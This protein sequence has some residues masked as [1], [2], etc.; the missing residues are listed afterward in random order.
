MDRKDAYAKCVQASSKLTEFKSAGDCAWEDLR[1]GIDS[2]AEAVGDALKSAK[3]R[4]NCYHGFKA[5]YMGAF[6]VPGRRRTGCKVP[7]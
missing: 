2:A 7:R 4:F 5:T 6:T 1:E 3:T